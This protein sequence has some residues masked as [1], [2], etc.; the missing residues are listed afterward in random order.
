MSFFFDQVFKLLTSE[1]GSLTYHLVL[2]FSIVGGLQAA[3]NYW[4]ASGAPAGR[5]P[6]ARVLAPPCPPHQ[7][8]KWLP[9]RVRRADEQASRPV[10]SPMLVAGVA[11][12]PAVPIALRHPSRR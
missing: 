12:G 2:A 7:Q 5:P 4:R 1:T 8:D 10:F 6:R 9:G 3:F 11:V